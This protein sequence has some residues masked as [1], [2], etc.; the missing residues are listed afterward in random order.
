L[1]TLE[2]SIPAI[3]CATIV[4]RP[5]DYLAR[6]RRATR[7][8]RLELTDADK[9]VIRQLRCDKSLPPGQ[10]EDM[11]RTVRTNSRNAQNVQW[12]QDRLEALRW[13][14]IVRVYDKNIR[15]TRPPGIVMPR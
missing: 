1:A 7:D 12:R 5:A 10:R 13:V 2:P 14:R 11:V 8:F 3:E 4:G 9:E 6:L 15:R